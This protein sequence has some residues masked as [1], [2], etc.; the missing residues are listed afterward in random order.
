MKHV[1]RI[2]KAS[3]PQFAVPVVTSKQGCKDNLSGGEVQVCKSAIKKD[4]SYP[5]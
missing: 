3:M 4:G 2:T 1:S 5:L